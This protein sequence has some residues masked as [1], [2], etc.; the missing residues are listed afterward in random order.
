[1]SRC[2]QFV[3]KARSKGS[4]TDLVGLMAR[5]PFVSGFARLLDKPAHTRPYIINDAKLD[6]AEPCL[7]EAVSP[8]AKPSTIFLLQSFAVSHQQ[9]VE[10]LSRYFLPQSQEPHSRIAP[11]HSRQN[12]GCRSRTKHALDC[13][14]FPKDTRGHRVSSLLRQT[15][16]STTLTL[17]VVCGG[18]QT[19]DSVAE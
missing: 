10:I 9:C 7:S 18:F 2:V 6:E 15:S 16:D 14:R 1:V 3:S 5:G 4:L 12:F 17:P 19:L 13:S 11:V 8:S